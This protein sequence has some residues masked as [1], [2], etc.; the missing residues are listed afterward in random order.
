MRRTVKSKKHANPRK[1]NLARMETPP[2]QTGRALYCFFALTVNTFV[3]HFSLA[4]L[5][6]AL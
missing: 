6:A 2:V 4:V 3:F 1:K 5:Q